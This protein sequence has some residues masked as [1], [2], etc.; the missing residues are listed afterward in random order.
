MDRRFTIGYNTQVCLRPI[1]IYI[2]RTDVWLQSCCWQATNG[3]LFSNMNCC[4][5]CRMDITWTIT[6]KRVA[7]PLKRQSF[8]CRHSPL[9]LL[10]LTKKQ[11]LA[12]FLSLR[13]PQKQTLLAFLFIQRYLW[14][15]STLQYINTFQVWSPFQGY[16][17][18]TLGHTQ[19]DRCSL[20]D[21]ELVTCRLNCNKIHITWYIFYRS[22]VEASCI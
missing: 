12:D 18:S 1:S 8:I 7:S 3:V 17:L 19:H 11:L 2:K 6:S 16:L 5:L 10:L 9:L 21:K 4:D 15:L 22:E 20:S 14:F 13:E